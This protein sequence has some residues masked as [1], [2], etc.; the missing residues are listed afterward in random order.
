[1]KKL[2]ALVLVLGLAAMANA[3][4][5]SWSVDSVN[6][7]VGGTVTVQLIADVDTV[8]TEKWVGADVGLVAEIVSITKLPAAGPNGHADGPGTT[9]YPGW[10]VVEALDFDPDNLPKVLSGAQFDVVIKGLSVGT[11][12]LNSDAY[13]HNDEL[14]VIVPEPATMILLGLGALVLRRKS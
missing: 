10:Y 4:V 13:G 11:Y 14:T 9:G 12:V 6:V 3:T 7:A 1:M 8:Y 2:L 5:L